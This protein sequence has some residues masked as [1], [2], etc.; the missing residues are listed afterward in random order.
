MSFSKA[1]YTIHGPLPLNVEEIVVYKKVSKRQLHQVSIE[2][3]AFSFTSH[4]AVPT[5]IL[6]PFEEVGV[7]LSGFPKS[8]FQPMFVGYSMITAF[9]N[10]PYSDVCHVF[11]LYPAVFSAS[12]K[13]VQWLNE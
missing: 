9:E 8:V 2:N 13:Q 6:P 1:W 12:K 7:Y 11:C 3:I 4:T 5:I 10:K